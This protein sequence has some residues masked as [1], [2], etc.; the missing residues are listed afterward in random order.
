MKSL[1]FYDDGNGEAYSNRGPLLSNS[2]SLKDFYYKYLKIQPHSFLH[3]GFLSNFINSN[4]LNGKEA[5]SMGICNVKDLVIAENN[6][7]NLTVYDIDKISIEASDQFRKRVEPDTRVTY[8][9]GDVLKLQKTDGEYTL[10]ILCQMDYLFSDDDFSLILKKYIS[11]GIKDVIVLTPSVFEPFTP[12]LVKFLE[13][14]KNILH[15]L[16]T[17]KNYKLGKKSQQYSFT[18]RRSLNHFLNLFKKDFVLSKRIDYSYPTGR[19][20]LFHFKIKI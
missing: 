13:F 3:A 9:C 19:I 14:L 15:S 1:K 4:D 20:N 11:L 17:Y 8:R 2:L 12:N 6:N 5:L 18:Y 16:S 7:L 10:G